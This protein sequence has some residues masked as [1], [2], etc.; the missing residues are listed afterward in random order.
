MPKKIA[1]IG[2]GSMGY[3]IAQSILAAG[4]QTFGFDVVAAQMHRFRAEGGEKA[5]EKILQQR[6]MPLPSWFSTRHRPKT[7]CSGR[8]ASC[9]EWPPG[10]S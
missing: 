2:L 4:H 10:V 1:V 3:G 5:P 9:P 6:S 7:F 8:R